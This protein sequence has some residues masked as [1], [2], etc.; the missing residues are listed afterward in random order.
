MRA[1]GPR[2]LLFLSELVGTA[3][4]VSIGL[5]VVILV[6]GAAVPSPPPYRASRC[7][8]SSP[9]SSSS[10]RSVDRAF[11]GRENEWSAHQPR[12]HSGLQEMGQARSQTALVYALG[13]LAGAIAVALDVQHFNGLAQ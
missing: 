11:A 5:S 12:C 9:A 6:F 10:H 1:A 3:L 4:L 7:E 2:W 8:G 13:Q